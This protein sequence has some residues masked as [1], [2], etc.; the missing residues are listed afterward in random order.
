M[1]D[2]NERVD[3][4]GFVQH[5]APRLIPQGDVDLT[6]DRTLNEDGQGE[7]VGDVQPDIGDLDQPADV[8][9][10]HHV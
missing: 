1:S 4:D 7:L 8:G 3:S 6:A 10:I 2:P 5:D 9:G